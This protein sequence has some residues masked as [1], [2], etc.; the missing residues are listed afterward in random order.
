[1]RKALEVKKLTSGVVIGAISTS[2]VQVSAGQGWIHGRIQ[3]C[4]VAV[5]IMVGSSL[6]AWSPDGSPKQLGDIR[7]RDAELLD[8]FIDAAANVS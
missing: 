3:C 1:M 4:P 8:A 5:L 6:T 2:T 7:R